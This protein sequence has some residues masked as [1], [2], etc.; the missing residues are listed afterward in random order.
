MF[1]LAACATDRPVDAEEASIAA[2]ATGLY[3][4]GAVIFPSGGRPVIVDHAVIVRGKKI[5]SIVPADAPIPRDL[6]VVDLTG[7]TLL[8][9]LI[10]S[11]TH[12]T[13]RE[14][15]HATAFRKLLATGVTTLRDLTGDPGVQADLRRRVEAGEL[16]GPRI[17]FAGP[18]F[19]HPNG[20]PIPQWTDLSADFIVAASRGVSDATTARATVR[21]V[22]QS[23]VDLIKVAVEDCLGQC[24]RISNEVI[25]RRRLP[26]ALRP[27]R[28]GRSRKASRPDRGPWRSIDQHRRHRECR[29]RR[30]RRHHRSARPLSDFFC[31]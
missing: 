30:A 1:A 19:T 16:V 14:R 28:D 8:P 13:L 26:W 18:V 21:E 29:S 12:L 5:E 10:D 2:D 20:Y 22:A 23:G 24:P 7:K 3:L 27:H 25:D 6:S 17:F 9:G 4:K 15:D 11:H 31:E